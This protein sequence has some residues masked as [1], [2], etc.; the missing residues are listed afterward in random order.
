MSRQCLGGWY[1]GVKVRRKPNANLR[2]GLGKSCTL[3]VLHSEVEIHG[4]ATDLW[5]CLSG[6][7][8]FSVQ[9]VGKF[10][11]AL[12]SWLLSQCSYAAEF[13]PSVVFFPRK[14]PLF[15][16]S[17]LPDGYSNSQKHSPPSLTQWLFLATTL[18][19]QKPDLQ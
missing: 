19:G 8:I 7:Q 1:C 11:L 6:V 14:V 5:S 2:V 3:E 9:G 17:G 16:Y 15:T 10:T 13:H 18:L 12:H 4:D